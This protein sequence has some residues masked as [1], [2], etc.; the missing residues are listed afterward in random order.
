MAYQWVTS[1][2]EN[3]DWQP[4]ARWVD[5]GKFLTSSGVSAGIDAALFWV[6]QLHGEAE[7]RRIEALT[8]YHWS[9]DSRDDP[10]A[11]AL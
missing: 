4:Q 9:N 2:A 7:A 6:K 8:E 1:L 3:V 5:D 10:Y 11:V